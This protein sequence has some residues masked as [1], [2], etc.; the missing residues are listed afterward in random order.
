MWVIQEVAV[1][2]NV[3]ILLQWSSKSLGTDVRDKIFALVGV[4]QDG[5]TLVPLVRRKGASGVI[6]RGIFFD[7]ISALNTTMDNLEDEGLSNPSTVRATRPGEHGPPSFR[8]FNMLWETLCLIPKGGEEIN[9]AFRHQTRGGMFLEKM[10]RLET[11]S[12]NQSKHPIVSP[13]LQR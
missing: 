9:I 12:A 11:L 2:A 7:T 6:V 13:D 3:K 10:L 5:P 1:A 4:S 8:Y